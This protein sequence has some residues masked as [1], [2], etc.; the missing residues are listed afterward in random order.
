MSEGPATELGCGALC[1][2]WQ[3]RSVEVEAG[4]AV[5]GAV[6]WLCGWLVRAK[7]EAVGLHRGVFAPDGDVD[8]FAGAALPRETTLGIDED[9]RP[10]SRCPGQ[11]SYTQGTARESPNLYTLLRFNS[12]SMRAPEG[13]GPGH[14]DIA[15]TGLPT[16]LLMPP[17]MMRT[18]DVLA[19]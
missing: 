6:V 3:A 19:P 12:D 9:A 4:R 2:V 8:R 14:L 10:W 5:P 1:H 16:R 7:D 17:P 18:E 11:T 13:N 15:E